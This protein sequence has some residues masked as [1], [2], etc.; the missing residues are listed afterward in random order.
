MM[1]ILGTASYA[2]LFEFV[3]TIRKHE[4]ALNYSD[5]MVGELTKFRD[6]PTHVAAVAL[7]RETLSKLTREKRPELAGQGDDTEFFIRLFD[8]EVKAR[9]SYLMLRAPFEDKSVTCD[10]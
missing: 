2:A 1:G 8:K 6:Q 10:Q 3:R 5:V 9:V 4:P 7:V